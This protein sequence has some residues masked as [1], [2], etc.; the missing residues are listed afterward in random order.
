MFNFD[1]R[2]WDI[3]RLATFIINSS[4]EAIPFAMIVAYVGNRL[5]AASDAGHMRSE[6]D[7][8]P[9]RVS[10]LLAAVLLV[11]SGVGLGI[12][13][14]TLMYATRTKAKGSQAAM[15][16]VNKRSGYYSR[17]DPNSVHNKREHY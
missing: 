8:K 1:F 10:R 9:E 17:L 15:V 14:I 2:F 5:P 6:T 16:V 3:N 12:P 4:L 13:L 11:V 7:R